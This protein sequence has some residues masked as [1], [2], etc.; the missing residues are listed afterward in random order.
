MS[1]LKTGIEF[2]IKRLESTES[3]VIEHAPDICKDLVRESIVERTV[4]LIV[5]LLSFITL[6][7]L[8]F[9]TVEKENFLF[10]SG[11][12]VTVLMTLSFL[13]CILNL[14]G[15]LYNAK[16]IWYTKACTK[17]FLLRSFREMIAESGG[18]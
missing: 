3:F 15:I 10:F 2:I 5:N 8:I 16:T 17:L 6:T 7:L 1:E 18:E 11:P 9:H 12:G 13:V 14:F 4:D